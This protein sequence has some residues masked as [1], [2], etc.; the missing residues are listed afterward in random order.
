M[1]TAH[2]VFDPKSKRVQRRGEGWPVVRFS[3]GGDAF[4]C[5]KIITA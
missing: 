2:Q 5:P 3:F 1:D 4:I